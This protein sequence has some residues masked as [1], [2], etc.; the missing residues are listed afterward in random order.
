MLEQRLRDV[1]RLSLGRVYGVSVAADFGSAPPL[2]P[3]RPWAVLRGHVSVS[4]SCAPPTLALLEAAVLREV[5]A[6]R[7][8]GPTRAEVLACVK[9]AR[10]AREEHHRTNSYWVRLFILPIKS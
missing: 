7:A 2:A 9:T 4:F 1:L 5:A 8:Q 6:L 10:T 3:E